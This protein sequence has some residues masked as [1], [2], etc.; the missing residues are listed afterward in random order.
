MHPAR[1]EKMMN[2]AE[3]FGGRKHKWIILTLIMLWAFL[4]VFIRTAA[5]RN[6]IN[7]GGGFYFYNVDS[8]DHLRRVTLGVHS[9]PH[10]PIFDSYAGYPSGMG[11]IWAPLYDYVLS[12][13]CVLLGGS[14]VT[15]E[16]VCFFANP[17]YAALTI[18]MIFL[19]A[20]RAFSSDVAGLAAAFFLAVNPG[21]ISGSI[22]M[23]FGHHVF[24][25]IVI[26]M[27]FGL[28]FLERD[29]RLHL[30]GKLVAALVLVLTIF[31]WRGSTVYWGMAFAT[32]LVRAVVSHN[33]KLSVDYAAA[34][35]LASAII[36]SFC[37]VNPWGTAGGFNFA[38]ISWFHVTALGVC[39]GILAFF[40]GL[41][42]RKTFPYYATGACVA[43]LLALFLPPVRSI[44]SQVLTGITFLRG[45]GDPWLESNREMH[46][47]FSRHDFL[48]SA[49]YLTAA[50][51]AVPVSAALAF[52]K[53]NRDGRRDRFLIT[54]VMW[55]PVMLLGL[56]IRYAVIAAVIAS[57][58]GGYLV[59]LAWQRWKG[60]GQRAATILLVLAFLVPSYTHYAIT[61]KDDL[62]P[63]M[64]YG[65]F[66][67]TG[68]LNW[69]R[70]NTP[71][72]SYYLN[73][74]SRP[75]YGILANW[76]LGAQ[77]YHV[78][79][80]P[81][82]A[83]AFGWEAH[84]FYEEN[85][86]MATPD[87][88]A[89]LQI[90][91][92]NGIRYIMLNSFIKFRGIYA[93][94]LDGERKGRLRPGIS[95]SGDPE[96]SMYER[97]MY[98]DGSAHK[99]GSGFVSAL[100]N[101]RLLFETDYG[102]MGWAGGRLSHYKVFEAVAGATIRGKAEANG[103]VFVDM[104][105]I[106]SAGRIMYFHDETAADGKGGFSFTVPYATGTV[107]GGSAALGAYTVSGRGMNERKVSI[108]EE[109][110]RSGRTINLP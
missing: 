17:F 76:D 64:K 103:R 33:R 58:A 13:L 71:K 9:F 61:L 110:V 43:F 36:A 87:Q 72:T 24:E 82:M 21:H 85:A 25:P 51:F 70:N 68:V 6:F 30:K 101:Y 22:P 38:V 10:V 52:L 37:L 102:S 67:G 65:L 62:P 44:L 26:L 78:A 27:L 55:S 23:N 74:Y 83:T 80:R 45:G 47:V 105:V 109:D 31:M 18:V 29:D 60:N 81:A 69:I 95:G 19:V 59:S 88:E 99:T 100:R 107:Q 35:A 54:L 92:E 2:H 39:S 3:A 28:P 11:Q 89:A 104:P 73:P 4:G 96:Q 50:W 91:K 20:K 1:E 98:Y 5:F 56:V 79:Q 48:F 46:G 15:I 40:G 63:Y 41:G 106:T 57:L 93:I 49:G 90:V 86:F 34:F 8:Y 32:V 77:I 75:E 14:R 53:W 94:A 97:L 66:G 84:G 42:E 12:A 108:S 7:P 16:T